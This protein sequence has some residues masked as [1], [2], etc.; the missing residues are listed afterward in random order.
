MSNAT[1]SQ[2]SVAVRAL[3]EFTAKRGDL[4]LRFTPAPS[5]QEGI[6]GHA[7]VTARRGVNYQREVKLEGL[8]GELQIKGRADGFDPQTQQIEEIKTYRGELIDMPANHRQLHW[9]QAKVYGHLVCQQLKLTKIKVALIYFHVDTQK[10]T[11]LVEPHSAQELEEF[12]Q[13]LCE[14]FLA[15]AKQE[16]AHRQR[17]DAAFKEMR[18]PHPNF[19]TGQRELSEAIYKASNRACSLLAQAPT[20]IGKTIGSLFPMLKA[21]AEHKLDKVFFLAAKTS[22]R[23]LALHAIQTLQEQ[24]PPTTLRSLE[25]VSKANACEFPENACHGDSCPLAKGFYDRLP[26]ARIAAVAAP[27][28]DQNQLR[29][30]A[31]AHQVCPYYLSTEMAKWCDVIVGDYNYYFDLNAMLYGLTLSESWKIGVLVD[32]AHNMVSRARDMYSAQLSQRAFKAVRKLAPS[33]LKKSLDRVN[34]QWNQFDKTADETHLAQNNY[35]VLPELP[36]KFI[37]ALTTLCADIGGYFA[38]NP[39]LVSPDLQQ[40]YFDTL[41]FTR[42]AESFGDHSIVDLSRTHSD[43]TLCLRNIVPAPFLKPR[44]AASHSSTLFSATLSPWNYFA[45][46]LGMPDQTAWIDVASPFSADQL[47]VNVVDTISTRYTERQHSLAPIAELIA[48]QYQQQP[49]NYLA[50]FSSFEYMDQVTNV[51]QQRFPSITLWPQTRRM[52]EEARRQFLAN[53][54]NHSQGIGFAVLGGAFAEGIDL[55]GARLIGAFIATLGLPQINPINEQIKQ[56]MQQLFGAGYDYTYLYPGIQKVVQAAGRVIRTTNDRG[57]I[58]LIDDRFGQA[59]I[60]QL[61][62]TWWELVKK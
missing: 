30:L 17:R 56:R 28:L 15:W 35:A 44:W 1:Q 4:D 12:F 18:F 55:P 53:F 42:L 7:Q 27:L 58:Y 34:R 31:L 51:V 37:Q 6:E 38:D 2:Y 3:C 46:L 60:Q 36:D 49:G 19:R 10:E 45:D 61:M 16:M 57:V 26:A 5:A 22:G 39:T 52:D 43:T 8:H 25:L 24:L 33:V 14:Q 32:E 23:Q 62:P 20:G 9:A 40:F 48:G 50:F 13:Q 41:L 47:A 59:Q 11:V 29:A 54:T 21:S